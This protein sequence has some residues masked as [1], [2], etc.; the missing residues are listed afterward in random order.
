MAENKYLQLNCNWMESEWLFPLS[1]GARLAFVQ[2]LTYIKAHGF[3]GR[4]KAK[5]VAIFAV[6]NRISE[7][8]VKELLDAAKADGALVEEDGLWILTGWAKHQGDST[9]AE[10]QARFRENRKAELGSNSDRYVTE[11]TPEN[12]SNALRNAKG[13]EKK[14]NNDPLSPPGGGK[15]RA[16]RG[17]KWA[18]APNLADH[19]PAPVATP[20]VRKVWEEFTGYRKD[21]KAD[22]YTASGLSKLWSMLETNGYTAPMVVGLVERCMASN[23]KGIPVEEIERYPKRPLTLVTGGFVPPVKTDAEIAEETRLRHERLAL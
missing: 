13:E 11:V 5:A 22:P 2:L 1:D 16:K 4:A 21:K 18:S 14:R 10:R 17:D 20:E 3:N 6:Q 23:W 12:T 15:P 7:A 19:V 8:S 9:N